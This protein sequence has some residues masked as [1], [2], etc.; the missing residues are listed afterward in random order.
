[1]TQEIDIKLASH[2]LTITMSRP[3]KKNALTLAMYQTM[4]EAINNAN[5][6]PQVRVVVITGT[7]DAFSS[8]NDLNDFL[9]A[10]P[11]GADSPVMQF[12]LAISQAEKP[13]IAAVN[14][15]AVGVGTTMLLH[16]DLAYAATDARFRLPFVNL[17][18]VPEAASSLLLPRLSG[19]HRAAELL[20]LG[21]IFDA[22]IA[23]ATGLVNEVLP[24]EQLM[25]RV[26]ERAQ[27][28]AAQPPAALRLTKYLLKREPDSTQEHLTLE[29]QHFVARLASPEANEALTAFKERRAPDFSRFE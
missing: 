25:E 7:G 16:C 5:A 28:L 9:G 10:P 15:L 18:L 14:G 26:R 8:G 1:M 21:E 20:M 19:Y 24:A 6:D 4:A 22:E 29:M 2:V 11:A 17:G 23:L 27:Q 13:L 3:E 12:L